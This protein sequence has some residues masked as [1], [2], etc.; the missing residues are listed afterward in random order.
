MKWE[1]G[2]NW[3]GEEHSVMKITGELHRGEKYS[4]VLAMLLVEQVQV[5]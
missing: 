5:Q 1:G 4:H 2:M 3:E